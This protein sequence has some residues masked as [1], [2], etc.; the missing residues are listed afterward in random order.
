MKIGL[1]SDTHGILPG[2][3]FDIFKEVDH[4]FHAGDI[5]TQD[6]INSL[7]IIGPVHAVYGNIDTWP[8]VIKYPDMY[9]STLEN[10]RICLIHDIVKPK[11]FSYQ[12]FKKNIEV[13]IVIHG[14]THIAN[15]EYFRNILYINPGSV[16]KPRGRV[17]GTV[18]ILDL[19]KYPLRPV[20]LE[21]RQ[22][23]KR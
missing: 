4:I 1:I 3:V 16:S 7:E 20:F 6:I 14:H 11:Y 10:R 21:V 5:G 18:A 19:S 9:I 17:S 2:S 22:D 12:L 23:T 13:D 8:I 15:T